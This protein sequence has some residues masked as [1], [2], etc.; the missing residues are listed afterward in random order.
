MLTNLVEALAL[1]TVVRLVG[2]VDAEHVLLQVWQ[3]GKRLL[4]QIAHQYC[5]Q[6]L[7]T[8]IFHVI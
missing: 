8:N 2:V 1:L 5:R 7:F 3:L 6:I 4:A